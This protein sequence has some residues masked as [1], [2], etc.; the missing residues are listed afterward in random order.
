MSDK[1]DTYKSASNNKSSDHNDNIT[2]DDKNISS[3]IDITSD[4]TTVTA[5]T[6]A[7]EATVPAIAIAEELERL[8]KELQ[9]A[10]E[11]AE[12][13]WNLLLRAKAEVENVRR[14]ASVDVEKA[15]KFS[16]ESFA[17]DLISVV[18]SFDKGLEIVI[19]ESTDLNSLQ[20][21]IKLTHKLLV[22]TV[23]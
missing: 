3:N 20:Q 11:K 14:R 18:D 7:Q 23:S 4:D 5:A 1:T 10:K 6:A 12:E 17:K 15:Y 16:I 13:N 9:Q 19:T 2:A 21:G 22:D 8:T